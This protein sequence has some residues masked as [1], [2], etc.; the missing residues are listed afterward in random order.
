MIK[1]SHIFLRQC[2]LLI[3]RAKRIVNH[4]VVNEDPNARIIR[5]CDGIL[6]FKGSPG[7]DATSL[8]SLAGRYDNLITTRFLASIDC[9]KI[10]AQL[11]DTPYPAVSGF[12]S[13]PSSLHLTPCLGSE[14]SNTFPEFLSANSSFFRHIRRARGKY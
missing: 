12:H 14:H 6:T 7:I 8:C 9:L 13:V 1:V 10:P 5:F 3:D 11:F 2:G 4:A